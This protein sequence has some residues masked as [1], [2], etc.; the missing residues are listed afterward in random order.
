[1]RELNEDK[2][3]RQRDRNDGGGEGGSTNKGAHGPL[4]KK[5]KSKAK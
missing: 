1:M 5:F 4:K 2:K 3:E